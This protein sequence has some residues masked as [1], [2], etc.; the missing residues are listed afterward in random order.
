MKKLI[1]S[2]AALALFAG[3]ASAG[4]RSYDLR[5]LDTLNAYTSDGIYLPAVKGSLPKQVKKPFVSV[6]DHT[7]EHQNSTL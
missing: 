6:I 2:V 4:Q 7:G 3:V 5:D 1:I